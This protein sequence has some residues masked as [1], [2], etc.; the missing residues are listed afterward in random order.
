MIKLMVLGLQK[1]WFNLQM[2]LD[3]LANGN[4]YLIYFSGMKKKE[5]EK[6]SR[7]GLMV[8]DMMVGGKMTKQMDWGD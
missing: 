3:T 8:Q 6:V 4:F 1:K 2:V 7:Y 5:K